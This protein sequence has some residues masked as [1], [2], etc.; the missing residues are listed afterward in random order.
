MLNSFVSR[1]AIKSRSRAVAVKRERDNLL[2]E[3]AELTRKLEER[4]D[5]LAQRCYE[6]VEL[7]SQLDALRE[8]NA[9]LRAA[10]SALL[11]SVE[12][13]DIQEIWMPDHAC[14]QCKPGSEIV[15][16][17]FKCGLHAA[18]AVLDKIDSPVK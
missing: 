15:V 2:D 7:T 18:R 5:V 3:V 16:P 14:K 11:A 1:A 10:L 4:G 13:D 6:I 8:L 12:L 9:E 17:G